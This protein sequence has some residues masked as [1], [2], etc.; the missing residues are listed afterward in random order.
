MIKCDW[1]GTDLTNVKHV[2]ATRE[3]KVYKHEEY[4][5]ARSAIIKVLTPYCIT[6]TLHYCNDECLDDYFTLP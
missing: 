6:K 4:P 3:D 5:F 1:C 2:T